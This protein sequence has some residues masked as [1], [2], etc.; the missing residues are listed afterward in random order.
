MTILSLPQLQAE[1]DDPTGGPLPAGVSARPRLVMVLG[2]RPPSSQWLKR[3]AGGSIWAVDRGADACMSAGVV[4]NLALGD[5]DSISLT[6]LGWLIGRGVEMERHSPDKDLTD[7]QLALRRAGAADVLVTGC[8]GGREPRFDHMFANVFSAL[9]AREWG[10]RV[11]AM[12]D[13]SEVL[14]P[15]FDGA[16]TLSFYRPPSAVSLL[17]LTPM[18]GSVSASG[19]KWP[20]D[21]AELVQGRPYAISNVPAA[22]TQVPADQSVP[23]DQQVRVALEE[24]AMGVYCAFAKGGA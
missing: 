2:G 1:F 19:V 17:P 7:F 14:L 10:A 15:L 24:G 4:P 8:W 11:L 12:A 16:V 22:G 23:A 3:V 5:F 18:C 9:W 13:D 20:L 6:G 21:G